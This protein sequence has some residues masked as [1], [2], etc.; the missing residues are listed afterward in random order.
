MT[1]IL[2]PCP[3][4]GAVPV[5]DISQSPFDL[6]GRISHVIIASRCHFTCGE[7][8]RYSERSGTLVIPYYLPSAF[9]IP[10]SIQAPPLR[11]PVPSVISGEMIP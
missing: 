2:I 6:S 4:R 5:L 9:V 8:L 1:A 10:E 7:C 3:A 11:L